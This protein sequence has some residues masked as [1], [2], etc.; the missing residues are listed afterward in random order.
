MVAREYAN[1]KRD[2]VHSPTSSAHSLRLLPLLFLSERSREFSDRQVVLG[3][4]DIKDAFLQV[5][6]EENLQIVAGGKR[7]RV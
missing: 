7:Y 3:A 1:A 2:D 5:L 4:L 6:G